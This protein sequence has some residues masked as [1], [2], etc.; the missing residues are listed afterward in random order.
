MTPLTTDQ[1]LTHTSL[2]RGWGHRASMI[3]SASAVAGAI[4][5]LILSQGLGLVGVKRRRAAGV[6]ETASRRPDSSSEARER[7]S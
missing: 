1:H 6:L 7:R 4:C 2:R 5:P 3:Q